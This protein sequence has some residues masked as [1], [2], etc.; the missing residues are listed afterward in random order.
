MVASV[1]ALAISGDVTATR[2]ERSARRSSV[3][4]MTSLRSRERVVVWPRAAHQQ[5][6]IFAVGVRCFHRRRQT[7]MEQHGNAVC[8]LD[9][10][11]EVLADDEDGS[12]AGSKI[13]QGLADG[14][15]RAGVDAPGRL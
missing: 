13:D 6:D 3:S 10:F 1:S 12:A 9:Q 5:A 4:R 15:R 2:T 11:I 7:S 8:D 14:R